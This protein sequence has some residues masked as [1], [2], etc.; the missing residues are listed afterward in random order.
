MPKVNELDNAVEFLMQDL[1][2]ELTD[3]H[4]VAF[5]VILA[6]VEKLRQ[7]EIELAEAL[8]DRRLELLKRFGE[9]ICHHP[10][11][12]SWQDDDY[13]DCGYLDLLEELQEL[14]DAKDGE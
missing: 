2:M 3:E 10:D 4:V 13:C 7:A 14:A 8:S 9:F 6:E 11:C 5:Q 12:V 1:E